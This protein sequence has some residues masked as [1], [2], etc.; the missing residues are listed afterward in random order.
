M[1]P[2]QLGSYRDQML[3]IVNG[4]FHTDAGNTNSCFTIAFILILGKSSTT[5]PLES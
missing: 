1:T 5:V 4:L 3:D 2:K